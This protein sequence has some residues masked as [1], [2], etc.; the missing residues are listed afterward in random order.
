MNDKVKNGSGSALGLPVA[1]CIAMALVTGLVSG[2]SFW[3]IQYWPLPVS[4]APALT[5][6]EGFLWGVVVGGVSGLILGFVTDD[7]HYASPES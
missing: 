3:V 4:V 7:A 1:A 6:P 2:G 5:F